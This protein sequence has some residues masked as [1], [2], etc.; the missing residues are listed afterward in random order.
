MLVLFKARLVALVVVTT[1]VGFLLATP[2]PVLASLPLLLPTLA[3]TAL[4]AAGSM[5]LNQAMEW[6]RDARMQRT[7]TRPVPTGILSPG[8]AALLGTGVTATGL[9]LLAARVNGLTAALGLVV[10]AVYLLVYTPL[11]V[12]TPACTLAG[13][14]CG[15]LPPMMGWTAATHSLPIGAWVLGGILFLWQ[16]PHFL[17]LAWLH[18]HDYQR[19][20]FRMLPA[21]DPSGAITGRVAAVYSLALVGLNLA[22]FLMGLAGALFAAGAAL[23]G[24][25]LTR[26]AVRLAVSRSEANA[27]RLFLATLAYLPLLLALM[28]ADR[29]PAIPGFPVHVAATLPWSAPRP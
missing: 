5:A 24:F 25:W 8:Q 21:V 2:S 27:R 29:G 19:G 16:I 10:V 12:R 13:A 7:L 11:K 9:A 28:V 14:I 17:A 22:A 15:A 3:G 20:G 26:Q 23:L 4:A 18:R 1:A 6:R